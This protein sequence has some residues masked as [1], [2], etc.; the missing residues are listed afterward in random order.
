MLDG[1]HLASIESDAENQQVL[2]LVTAFHDYW[3][4][5]HFDFVSGKWGWTDGTISKYSNWGD[6]NPKNGSVLYGC[7]DFP[8][9]AYTSANTSGL[10]AF[11]PYFREEFGIFPNVGPYEAPAGAW[12]NYDCN[13]GMGWVVGYVCSYSGST[14]CASCESGKYSTLFGATS[15]WEC[16]SCNV[17]KYLNTTCNTSSSEMEAYL[18]KQTPARS[19]PFA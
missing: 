12:Y 19:T 14:S 9:Y 5:Y 15:P 17:T 11:W 13:N 18:A 10:L 2:N 3:I 7:V 16:A 1:G 8:S 6:A 4:G